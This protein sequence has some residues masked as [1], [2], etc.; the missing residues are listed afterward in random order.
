ML[1]SRLATAARRSSA[2][3]RRHLSDTA[4]RSAEP[5]PRGRWGLGVAAAIAVPVAYFVGAVNPPNLAL[6]FSPRY[7]PPPPDRESKIGKEITAEIERE[8]QE[9]AVVAE[10]RQLGEWY[11]SRPYEKYDPNK[12]HNSL[13]A[14]SLRGPGKLAVPPIAFAKN[15]ESAGVVVLHLGRSLCGHDGIIHGGLLATVFDET[16][17]RNAL[18]NIPTHIGVTANLNINYRSPCMADQ[19][20]VVRTRLDA[21]KGR[22]VVVSGSME[23]LDGE[24]LADATA[25]FV[26]PKWAQFLQS[27]GVT[28]ALGAPAETAEVAQPRMV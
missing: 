2:A 21:K 12:I 17:A 27:S 15:D 23:T 6:M 22:K 25:I 7:S 16:L 1:A 24:R 11:E 10:M 18:M 19:F 3:A 5:A 20:V 14:G 4:A 28:D 8:L 26:E 13:T 9:L